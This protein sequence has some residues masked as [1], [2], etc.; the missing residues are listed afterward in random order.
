MK[1]LKSIVYVIAQLILFGVRVIVL[2]GDEILP[3]V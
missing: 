3:K 2:G 1:I